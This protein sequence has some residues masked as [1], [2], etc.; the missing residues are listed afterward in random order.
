MLSNWGETSA[1]LKPAF[2][3]GISKNREVLKIRT[4]R[5]FTRT[6]FTHFVKKN[7]RLYYANFVRIFLKN[8]YEIVKFVRVE[9]LTSAVF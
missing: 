1:P 2:P 4:H 7:V 3:V 5:I 8:P 9:T 6:S